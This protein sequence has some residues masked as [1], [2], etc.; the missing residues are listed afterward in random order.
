MEENELISVIIPIYNAEKYLR[1][2]LESVINQTYK[3][4]EII[5]VNDGSTDGSLSICYEYQK[6]DSRIIIISQQNKGAYKAR[7]NAIKIAN[8]KYVTFVDGDDWIDKDM[9]YDLL[10]IMK[11]ND[12][13]MVES[14]Y[15][16]VNGE[17]EKKEG[18]K[19]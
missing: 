2:C 18:G 12:T 19:D 17:N 10:K 8:G 4:L 6:K 14:G 5:L 13:L 1:Q 15:I 7:K 16:D 11:E 3:Q 9:Y